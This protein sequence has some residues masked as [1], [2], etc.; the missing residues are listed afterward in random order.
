MIYDGDKNC[1]ICN[2]SLFFILVLLL[3]NIYCGFSQEIR[4]PQRI[5][6]I[7]DVQA[8][9]WVERV[10]TKEDSNEEAR[11]ALFANIILQHPQDLFMLGDLTSKGS[12]EKV[13]APLD[14][15]LHSLKRTNTSVYAIPGNH[16]YMGKSSKGLQLFK[17]R[18]QE[19]W[20]YGYCVNIDS[21]A[22][23]MLNSN[24]KQLGEKQLSKQLK[25]YRIKMDSLDADPGIKAIIVC[26]HHAPFT[27]SD[28]VNPSQ[29]VLDSIVPTFENSKKS[30]LFI[31]GHSHNLEYFP[32]KNGKHFLV[33]GGGGGLRQSLKPM[34]ERKSTDLCNQDEKPR[35]FYL[36]I[37]KNGNYLKL[38]IT[39]FKK[40]FKF[41]N[42][43]IGKIECN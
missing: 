30:K 1:H 4:D 36:V 33:I 32:G 9:M 22:M 26:T 21:L 37:E 42:L 34:E 23:V 6:F 14:T 35:F 7:S 18:F 15:F 38:I 24:F 29:K 2:N 3:I 40:D 13:W 8:P 39:G 5:Y 17:Q 12:K 27:N 11:D 31:S 28:V 19:Q 20:L 16:E 43:D 41:F 25:W 10:I